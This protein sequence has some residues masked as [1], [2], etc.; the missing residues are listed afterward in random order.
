MQRLVQDRRQLRHIAKQY[1][2]RYTTPSPIGLFAAMHALAMS[3]L[4]PVQAALT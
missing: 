4:D 3:L 2:D 1:N